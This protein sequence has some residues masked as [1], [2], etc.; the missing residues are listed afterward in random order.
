[1]RIVDIVTILFLLVAVVGM[2]FVLSGTYNQAN[3]TAMKLIEKDHAKQ[4]AHKYGNW[5]LQS[6][7][8][9]ETSS[10]LLHVKNDGFVF[11]SDETSLQDKELLMTK[12]FGVQENQYVLLVTV[13]STAGSN[14][15]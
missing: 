2:I 8:G 13:S 5:D 15:E 4:I 6:L 14:R 7:T 9:K 3:Q 10:I 1:M 12:L 11:V